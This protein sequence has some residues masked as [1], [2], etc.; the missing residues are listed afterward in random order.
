MTGYHHVDVFADRPY[1]G[2]SLA[3]FVDP[4]QLDAERMLRVTQELRHFETIFVRRQD[5]PGVVRARV[6]DLL[7][8]LDFAGHP[9]LG[10]AAV[11]HER[12]GAKPGEERAW[13]FELKAGTV[14][15][16]TYG[17]RPGQ[18]SALLDQGR[19]VFVPEKA[20]LERAAVAEAFGLAEDDLDAG[21]PLEIVSTGLRYLIVAV[22]DGDALARARI[23]HPDL[24]GVLE[25]L[26]AQFAYVLD[27]GAVEG[28]HWNNDGVL[29]DVAT[30]S[31][32]GCVAAYLLRH[33]RARDGQE[34]SLAQGRF[35]GRPS[36][37]AITAHGTADDVRRVTVGGGVASVG[38]G[39]LR[40]LP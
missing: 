24:G 28:R 36:R 9:V 22:R 12:A 10:A 35:T 29:E 13:T 4:P 20:P 5:A 15:V 26:G 11:L 27:A 30:G 14:R 8:E 33:G 2:N 34:L 16:T 38:T 31:A 3:V 40:V 32:A 23:R 25:R 18:V 21:L 37:I 17:E 6:F 1:T 7:E 39:S 19:P